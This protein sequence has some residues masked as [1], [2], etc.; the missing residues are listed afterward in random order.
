MMQLHTPLREQFSTVGELSHSF[1]NIESTGLSLGS[2]KELTVR[3]ESNGGAEIIG[4]SASA[5]VNDTP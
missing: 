3:I 1:L 4:I 2:G 5:R